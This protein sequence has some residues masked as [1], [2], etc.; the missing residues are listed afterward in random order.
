MCLPWNA[1]PFSLSELCGCSAESSLAQGQSCKQALQRSLARSIA[2]MLPCLPRGSLPIIKLNSSFMS[3]HPPNHHVALEG[4]RRADTKTKNTYTTVCW[5]VSP[6]ETGVALRH[7]HQCHQK[8]P[9]Y[10]RPVTF[11]FIGK[12]EKIST[13]TCL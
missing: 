11:T 2:L 4:G 9:K 8:Y 5:T 1:L 6:S 7:Q 10:Q 12:N 13:L 3:T